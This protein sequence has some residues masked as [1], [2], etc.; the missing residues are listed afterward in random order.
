[1]DYDSLD[2]LKIIRESVF[3]SNNRQ[4]KYEAED[5]AKRAYYNL[6][7]TPGM[8]CQEYFKHI[9]HLVDI[10]KRLGGSLSG[11]MHLNDELPAH[12][13]RGGYTVAQLKEVRD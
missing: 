4:Y 13:A 11:D 9:R 3:K 7:Q 12:P 8:S 1:M 6:R 2:L 10:I 5:Q